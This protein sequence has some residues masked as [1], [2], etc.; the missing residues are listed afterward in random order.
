MKEKQLWRHWSWWRRCGT[1][2][3]M[4][5]QTQRNVSNN[6]ETCLTL[7]LGPTP[8]IKPNTRLSLP[9]REKAD[10]RKIM[11]PFLGLVSR[12][13][14]SAL[15]YPELGHTEKRNIK[16]VPAATFHPILWRNVGNLLMLNKIILQTTFLS[17]RHNW[18]HL[19]NRRNYWRVWESVW[20]GIN[21]NIVTVG[22]IWVRPILGQLLQKEHLYWG[23]KIQL[24]NSSKL[25]SL[26]FSHQK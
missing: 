15:N 3:R 26:S 25:D 19:Y 12:L 5:G 6:S 21:M 16:S 4:G 17:I 10:N 13:A 23:I 2:W 11:N 20:T 1:V 18:S 8:L 22:E 7:G 9:A 14:L 24:G